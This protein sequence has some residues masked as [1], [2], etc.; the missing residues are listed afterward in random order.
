V[1]TPDSKLLDFSNFGA[2]L[3]SKLSDSSV[4]IKTS[5]GSEVFNW[6][7]W[8][9][10]LADHCVCVGWVTYD[11]SLGGALGVVVDS[12]SSGDE[13][14]SVVFEE[15]S[16]FHTWSTG[17][18][19]DEEVEIDI[20]EGNC[21]VTCDDYVVEKWEG[22]IVEFGLNTLKCVFSVGKIK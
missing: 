21:E 8:G 11:D 2:C 15:I 3:E 9:V 18:G 7:A 19:T 10:V 17:L 1:V 13:N 22:A 6:D 20:L 5:H 4:V 12:F 16:T 14:L